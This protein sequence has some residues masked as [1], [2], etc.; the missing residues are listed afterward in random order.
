[1]ATRQ[2]TG[3]V[4]QC[5]A[6]GAVG[7]MVIHTAEMTVECEECSEVVDPAA[8]AQ[9]LRHAAA[10]WDRFAA[11]IQLASQIAVDE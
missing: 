3:V 11:W 8:A 10:C 6:C 2:K 1:M 7:G 4:M 9:Q 5:P